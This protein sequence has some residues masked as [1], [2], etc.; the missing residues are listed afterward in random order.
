MT[1]RVISLDGR[2]TT[3]MNTGDNLDNWVRPRTVVLLTLVLLAALWTAVLLSAVA[4]RQ[5]NGVGDS[6]IAIT[7]KL[8]PTVRT[9]RLATS[10][11]GRAPQRWSAYRGIGNHR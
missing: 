6:P 11:M 9:S 8:Q 1:M 4:D 3:A 10:D 7:N 2:T 5:D